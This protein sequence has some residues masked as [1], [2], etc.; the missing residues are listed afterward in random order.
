MTNITELYLYMQNPCMYV[1]E[2]TFYI[3]LSARKPH[4]I[5]L[6]CCR[7]TDAGALPVEDRVVDLL[8]DKVR[9]LE[10]TFK[11]IESATQDHVL[12]KL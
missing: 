10:D 7:R 9:V 1:L 8:H 12:I 6:K 5:K 11:T 3:V 2:L 4:Q